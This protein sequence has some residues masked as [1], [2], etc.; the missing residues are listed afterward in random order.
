MHTDTKSKHSRS[1]KSRRRDV[2]GSSAQGEMR[3][4]SHLCKDTIKKAD[5][6]TCSSYVLHKITIRNGR[7][8][9]TSGLWN[10]PLCVV[11]L[12]TRLSTLSLTLDSSQFGDM[13]S[14]FH[15]NG[16][17]A[18]STKPLRSMLDMSI[19]YCW[20]MRQKPFIGCG[21]SSRTLLEQKQEISVEMHTERIV[22]NHELIRL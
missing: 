22:E 17:Y 3:L 6:P 14:S 16:Y 5:R 1:P 4:S 15:V 8:K 13:P 20:S 12:K 21:P 10:E 19:A 18:H 11:R 2:P 7:E 9:D